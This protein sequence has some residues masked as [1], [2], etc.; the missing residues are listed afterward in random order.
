MN[1]PA[2]SCFLEA[3]LLEYGLDS[4]A[5]RDFFL[6]RAAYR[7]EKGLGLNVGQML[8]GQK[9]VDHRVQH[10]GAAGAMRGLCRPFVPDRHGRINRQACT[11][12]HHR[13]LRTRVRLGN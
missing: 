9:A 2:A 1:D 13:L 12:S 11:R 10:G 4:P 6:E 5:L 3:G 7:L 8:Y